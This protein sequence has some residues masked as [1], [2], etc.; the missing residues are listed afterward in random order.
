M[1]IEI[2]KRKL[3]KEKNKQFLLEQKIKKLKK[4][5]S[6]EN[7]SSLIEAEKLLDNI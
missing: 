4:N 2:A 6:A 7:E 3:E 5:E 1:E